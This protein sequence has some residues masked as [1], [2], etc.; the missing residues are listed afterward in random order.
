MRIAKDGVGFGA[1]L[2]LYSVCLCLPALSRPRMPLP[3]LPEL[4]P[5]LS[6]FD[7]DGPYRQGTN[8][9]LVDTD[10]DQLI[11]S[12]SGYALVRSHALLKPFVVPAVEGQAKTGSLSRS[13]QNR[14]VL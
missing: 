7:F 5:L 3:P 6:R 10:D 8:A 2:I 13:F 9:A 11:E 14:N 12:W 4:A 1:L